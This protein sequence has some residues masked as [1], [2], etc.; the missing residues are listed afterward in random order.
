MTLYLLWNCPYIKFRKKNLQIISGI[1]SFDTVQH[2]TLFAPP[3]GGWVWKLAVLRFETRNDPLFTLQTPRKHPCWGDTD[4]SHNKDAVP[5]LECKCETELRRETFGRNR[6][7]MLTSF[8]FTVLHY[9]LPHS[10]P[11]P[12]VSASLPAWGLVLLKMGHLNVVAVLAG[13]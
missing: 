2:M 8:F 4:L 12:P 3:N 6:R 7:S 1:I 13:K 11:P 5:E 10:L 9:C